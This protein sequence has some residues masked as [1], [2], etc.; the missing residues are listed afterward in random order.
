MTA[1]GAP[2]M[3]VAG[4]SEIAA[5]YRVLLVD[6][7][8]TL[9]D[10][11]RV[12][13]GVNAALAA[14]RAAGL[15]V[16]VVTNSP[17]RAAQVN[18]HLQATGLLPQAFDHVAC[19]GEL[20][21]L[22]LQRRYPSGRPKLSFIANGVPAGWL[23]AFDAEHVRL[24]QADI[25]IAYGMPYGSAAAALD[26]P[27][28]AGLAAAHARGV[29]LLVA[30]SDAV[31]PQGGRLRLGPGWIADHYRALGGAVVEFGKPHDPVFDA[32]LGLAGGAEPGQVLMIGDNLAT[33][34]RGACRRGFDSL[35]V[36]DG[37]VHDGC[38][39]AALSQAAAS[40]DAPTYLSRNLR[41]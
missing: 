17:R 36:L 26:S 20:A 19:S 31:Y 8:G 1:A 14:A 3:E 29:P 12:F 10:G 25:A 21:W 6:A 34:I 13:A 9:H 4:L 18:A 39:I 37:G 2:F 41:W 22:D 5:R 40:G 27:L 35:L 24:E 33:D 32:A 7:W 16:V 38:D 15:I 30:D 28:V 11:H 23:G